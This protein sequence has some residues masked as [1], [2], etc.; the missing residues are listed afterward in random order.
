MGPFDRGLGEP[1]A[2]PQLLR[3][4]GGVNAPERQDAVWIITQLARWGI[5]PFPHDWQEVADRVQHQYLYRRVAE[6]QGDQAG[7]QAE[8]TAIELFGSDCLDLG[9]PLAYLRRH[10][11]A[12]LRAAS[13]N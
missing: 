1:V 9:D 3:F 13:A 4:H 11:P 8:P 10:A 12:A 6:A 7:D 5:C 2:E